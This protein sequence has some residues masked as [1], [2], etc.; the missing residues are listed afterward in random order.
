M[1]KMISRFSGD[2]WGSIRATISD[3]NGK[4]NSL[5]E[6]ANKAMKEK[7]AEARMAIWRK[8]EDRFKGLTNAA[9][10]VYNYLHAAV[11]GGTIL[12]KPIKCKQALENID[13]A[14]YLSERKLII[15]PYNQ[16]EGDEDKFLLPSADI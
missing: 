1:A 16:P 8:E 12:A 14:Y 6:V 7:D 5:V 13:Q 11:K 4:R 9:Q 10:N 3:M 2:K 15:P